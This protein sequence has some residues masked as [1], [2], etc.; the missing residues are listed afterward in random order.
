MKINGYKFDVSDWKRGRG[1]SYVTAYNNGNE[2]ILRLLD[3]P[4]W[5]SEKMS[6]IFFKSKLQEC[7]NYINNRKKIISS[8]GKP[9]LY[10]FSLPIEIFSDNR[11]IYEVFPVI[12]AEHENYDIGIPT[13][14]NRYI[15]EYS[16]GVTIIFWY[17]KACPEVYTELFDYEECLDSIEEVLMDILPKFHGK[18]IYYNAQEKEVAIMQQHSFE[19]LDK[20]KSPY[21]FLLVNN[22]YS[23]CLYYC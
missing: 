21:A 4:R 2:F 6:D 11:F 13:D 20:S 16:N 3:H 14:Q 7:Q 22:E 5:P 1:Y 18:S 15:R 12:K 23:M 19:I 8:L 17:D 10:L 9:T